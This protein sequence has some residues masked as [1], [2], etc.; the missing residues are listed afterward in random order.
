MVMN[1][2]STAIRFH[3]VSKKF[4]LH[5]TQP[6][7]FQ[8]LLLRALR[9][10]SNRAE[11][12]WA[13]RDVCLDIAPGQTVGFIGPNG[14][15]KSTALK[16]MAGILEPTEGTI[17]VNGRLAALL[18]LGAGFH[19]DLSGRE[20]I[21]LNGALLG[22][23]RADIRRR[24][25]EIV[26]FAELE[27]FI[28]MPVKHYSSGMYVRLGFAVAVH[29]DPDILLVDEVL[30]VGDA[31]FQRKCL[32]RIYEMKRRGVTIV[33]VSHDLDT[34]Q[35][36]CDTA[37]WFE[38][39]KVRAVGQPTDVVMA[40]MNRTTTQQRGN[41]VETPAE[42]Q[43]WGTGRI[44]I[45][46]VQL[47]SA[48]GTPARAFVTGA[49]MLIRLTF[50]ADER[51]ENP[52]FGI[53]IHHQNGT[54]ICGPNTAF[55]GVRIPAVEGAGEIAYRIPS[56]PLLPGSYLVSVAATNFADTE[57]FD[58]HDRVYSFQVYPGRTAERYG[59]IALGGTWEVDGGGPA[60]Q[61]DELP[62][63]T[64]MFSISCEQ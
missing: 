50:E 43:R 53:A 29:L 47:C 22:F 61:A 52:V 51:V 15:G 48:D 13:L 14:S 11:E 7:S 38:R 17:A 44:R 26:A 37:V 4:T 16:L 9:R 57:I 64:L 21:Y 5:H 59:L 56:L 24:F 10:E 28:D 34:V 49:T 30:A 54:H 1:E 63:D 20:N 25:D 31:A 40:Y 39:G 6:R 60:R 19:P 62:H 45:T 58:Y 55:S 8:E 35:R 2:R 12:F 33:L 36:L 3:H 32:E 27:S 23:S 41:R 18:E 42:A 46:R